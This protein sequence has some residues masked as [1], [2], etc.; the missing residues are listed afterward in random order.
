MALPD[1]KDFQ[2]RNALD[3]YLSRSM[4]KLNIRIELNEVN[5]LLELI[6]RAILSLSLPRQP[7]TTLPGVKAIP[8]EMPS[9]EMDGCVHMLKNA[10]RKRSSLAFI[11]LLKD[12]IAVR[13]RVLDF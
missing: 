8:I 11:K 12:S 10:Y 1:K 5:I 9:N 7:S 6:K 4:V 13:E 3:Q 2:A